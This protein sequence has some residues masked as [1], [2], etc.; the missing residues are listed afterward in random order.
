MKDWYQKLLTLILLGGSIFAWTTIY[1]DFVRFHAIYGT[2]FKIFDCSVPNPVLTPCF[3]G[4][5]GFLLASYWSIKSQMN[6]L[7]YLLIGCVIF[8]W[9]NFFYEVYKFYF[10]QAL[11]KVSCSGIPTNSV[12][13]TPCFYGAMIFA[14]S[15]ITIVY[16]RK[17]V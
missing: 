8:A 6:N 11:V 2:F 16:Y 17:N 9:S 7:Y 1:N 4:G 13:T 5:F 3:Y 15:F 12:F 10:V 14:L